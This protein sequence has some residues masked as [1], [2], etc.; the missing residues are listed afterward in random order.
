MANELEHDRKRASSYLREAWKALKDARFHAD[1]S[2][3]KEGDVH[4]NEVLELM[5]KID[6]MI[7][8]LENP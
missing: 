3:T 2:F 1:Q 6:K 7:Y 8:R 4:Y 5:Q